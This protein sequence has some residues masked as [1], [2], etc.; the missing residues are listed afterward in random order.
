MQN[1]LEKSYI[2]IIPA[3]FASTRFPGKPL[4]DLFGKPMI[5]RVYE[6]AKKAF[7]TVYV[8]T[9]DLRIFDAV[10]G[11]GGKAVMTLSSHTSGT[12]RL[13]EAI[14][15]IHS[16]ENTLFDI[17]V[18]IQGD[19]PLIKPEQLEQ[20]KNCFSTGNTQIATLV[21]VITDPSDIFN[22]NIPKVIINKEKEALFFSRSSIPH[23]RGYDRSNWIQKHKFYKHIGIYAY[24]YPVLKEIT[25]LKPSPLEIA[26][27]LEQLRWIENNYRIK[28]EVTNFETIAIDTPQDLE[29]IKLNKNFNPDF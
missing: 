8:A 5:Q 1:K 18:N 13:A 16:I 20:V 2:G 28:V 21:K 29:K 14:E 15:K 22:P 24:T 26:E 6:Q 27:S 25:Q 10:L 12:D 17:I 9:D 3:R 11:F 7:E 23:I 19:E 4:V